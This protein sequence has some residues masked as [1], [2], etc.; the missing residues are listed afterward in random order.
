M[1]PMS[2]MERVTT[3][4]SAVLEMISKW[5]EGTVC[6]I[7]R[8]EGCPECTD[9]I[10]NT[11]DPHPAAIR[12]RELLTCRQADKEIQLYNKL[13]LAGRFHASF[14][15]VGTLSGRMSGGGANLNPQAINNDA[16]VRSAFPLAFEGEYLCGG[17]FESFEVCIADAVYGDKALR[18]ELLLGKKI[19]ALFGMVL[20]PGS[21]YEEVKNDP[22]KYKKS[23][24]GVFALLYGGNATTLSTRLGV[25]TEVAENALSIWNGKYKE[26]A[27]ARKRIED[28][29]CPVRF[30]GYKIVWTEPADY[31]ESLF[32]NRRYFTLENSIARAL[33][34]IASNPPDHWPKVKVVRKAYKG[35]QTV[36]NATRSALFGAMFGI[37]KANVR[38]AAN[39]EIQAT[40]AEMNKRLQASILTLQPKGIHPWVVRMLNIHDELMVVTKVDTVRERVDAF[41]KEYIDIIPLL[42]IDWRDRIATWAGKST[43]QEESTES[44]GLLEVG[45]ETDRPSEEC[46]DVSGE[47]GPIME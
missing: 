20:Y 5:C 45:S 19:H 12:A 18:A 11:G 31:V 25:S 3:T 21:T 41:I 28:K 27:K 35:P 43:I 32:G 30:D 14:V 42:A 34:Q 9:G 10:V 13:L 37:L 23:K 26:W 38:A 7:C 16:L 44:D 15:V 33:A 36:T 1:E 22:V 4:K 24:Q 8:G 6:T 47:D 46:W 17:D 2:E 29:F 39:H 40:G